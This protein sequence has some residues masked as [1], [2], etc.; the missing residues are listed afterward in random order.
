MSVA[1]GAAVDCFFFDLDLVLYFWCTNI[2]ADMDA[3]L[4]E[5][6]YCQCHHA[7]VTNP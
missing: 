1:S 7:T 4:L 6:T 5:V 3:A 2:N